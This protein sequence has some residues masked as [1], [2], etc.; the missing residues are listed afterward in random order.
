[1]VERQGSEHVRVEVPVK[2][3]LQA[4]QWG[5]LN[6]LRPRF[7]IQVVS[8]KQCKAGRQLPPSCG[9]DALLALCMTAMKKRAQSAYHQTYIRLQNSNHSTISAFLCPFS[10]PG[11]PSVG[12]AVLLPLRGMR[13]RR[14]SFD[15]AFSPMVSM[16]SVIDLD[17]GQVWPGRRCGRCVL[18]HVLDEVI[19]GCKWIYKIYGYDI[20][21]CRC[22]A[23]IYSICRY[24]WR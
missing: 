16:P 10:D 11:L 8:T 21:G 20:H 9:P 24:K 5:N 6:L 3:G 18:A 2:V 7:F 13:D 22:T 17:S 1:M 4:K 15:D 23:Y 14:G 19:S 12:S